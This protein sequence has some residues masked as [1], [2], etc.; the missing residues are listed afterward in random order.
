V[1]APAVPT[2][3][4]LIAKK[5][6]EDE[7]QRRKWEELHRAWEINEAE[8]RRAER[9]E[10]RKK[11]IV[12][13]IAAWRLARDIRAYISE[14]RELVHGE[15]LQIIEG[16]S[17]DEDLKWALSYAERIDPLTAWRE[18]IA[19]AKTET[20]ATP[21]PDCGKIHGSEEAPPPDASSAAPEEPNAPAADA[22]TPSD[23]TEQ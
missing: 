22:V 10:A 5:E 4:K 21:C 2:I 9:E 15:G 19:R 11:Q 20:A 12:E 1:R 8:R 7:E 3:E 17:A 14:V 6:R 13:K 18:D 23:T 16:A